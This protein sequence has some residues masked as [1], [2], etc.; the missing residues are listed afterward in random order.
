MRR[1]RD[2]I[3]SDILEAIDSKINRISSIMK[4]VNLSASLAK[5][6]ISMLAEEGLIQ[7]DNGEYKLTEKGRKILEQ[8]RNMRKM[9][10]ELANIIYEVRKEPVVF[11]Q[12]YSK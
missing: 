11:H 1:T 3:I 4:N 8:L 2:D 7:D 12:F 6:Y 5:K 10:L 9:E